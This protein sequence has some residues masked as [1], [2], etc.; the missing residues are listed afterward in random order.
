MR[1]DSM[2]FWVDLVPAPELPVNNPLKS[3]EEIEAEFRFIAST[4]RE[5]MDEKEISSATYGRIMKKVETY[6]YLHTIDEALV[7]PLEENY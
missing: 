1:S 2:P 3:R 7:G 4:S 5:E 6:S